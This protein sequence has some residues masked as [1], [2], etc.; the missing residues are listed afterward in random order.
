MVTSIHNIQK[1]TRNSQKLGNKLEDGRRSK[2]KRVRMKKMVDAPCESNTKDLLK[3]IVHYKMYIML[4]D[5]ELASINKQIDL[6]KPSS[7]LKLFK[8]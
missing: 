2:V 3:K 5:D 4:V 8:K 6:N 1:S 7:K